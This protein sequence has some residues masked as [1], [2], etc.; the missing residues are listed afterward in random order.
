MTISRPGR[1]D[2]LH[3]RRR[4][5]AAGR[6]P[7]KLNGTL[8]TDIFKEYIAQKEWIYPARAAPEADRR[9]DGVRRRRDPGLQAAVG[10]GLPHPRGRLDGRAGAGVHPGRRLRLRRARPVARPGRRRVRARACRSS[11]TRTSTSSRRSPSCA[12]P[13]GSGPA[14]CATSTAR[15]PTKAQWLRFH[16]Q[17]AGVSLTAQQPENNI[18]RT[19]IEAL[20]AVLGGT[21]SLHTNALD[22]VLALPSAKAAQIALRTQQVIAEETGVLNVAD[23]LG[24]SWYVEALTDR[25]EAEAEAIFDADQGAR[26]A[27]A[28]IT[29]GLLRGIEDGWF[30]GR[31]RRRRVRLPAWRWRRATSGSSASTRSPATSATAGDPA[32]LARGRGG[33]DARARR[34]PC[35]A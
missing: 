19:A 11:S 35:A 14:G 31:D 26:A 9:P 1:A 10:V 16:T 20:A 6:R 4:R 23:P 13:A 30:I 25:L 8:Q 15:R 12:P 28:A 7:G 27:T 32:R 18:V 34:A 22:E 17:T 5:R 2:L 33:A 29:A 24:G 21:N 3:V